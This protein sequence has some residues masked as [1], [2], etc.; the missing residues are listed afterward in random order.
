LQKLLAKFNLRIVRL[1]RY[2]LIAKQLNQVVD[3]GR[4]RLLEMACMVSGLDF[5]SLIKH[6]HSQINQDIFVISQLKGLKS[7]FFVEFGATDGLSLSNT[8]QLEKNLDWK[9]ILVEP[10]RNWKEKLTINRNCHIDFRCVAA[11]T[12][13]LVPF[14][15]SSSPELSTIK[16]FEGIDENFRETSKSYDVESV[17]LEDLLDEN[18]AP[19]IID[20]LSIDTEG[21]EFLILENFNFSKYKFRV[22]TCEHNFTE[23]REKIFKL[24]SKNGY[25]RV[26]SE[27]TQFDDWY[28]HPELI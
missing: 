27:F 2:L 6:S 16:G 19:K 11:K 4:V 9:G 7:G 20:Y 26:W 22:I 14:I 28:V 23:N 10:G 13:D 5:N 18:K 3:L 1:D 21:S 25:E 12:G 17:S 15:E 8:L 24:L